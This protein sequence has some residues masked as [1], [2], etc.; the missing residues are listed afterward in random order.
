[1]KITKKYNFAE[2]HF[3]LVEPNISYIG[4]KSSG[5][6]TSTIFKNFFNNNDL[7]LAFTSSMLP[8]TAIAHSF[9]TLN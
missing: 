1:M 3:Y 6:I 9:M 4:Y 8:L 7:E 2:I 5:V